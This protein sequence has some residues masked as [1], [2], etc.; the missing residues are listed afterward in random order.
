MADDHDKH[1]LKHRMEYGFFCF[2][3]WI[4]AK[5]PYRLALGV[6]WGIA[7]LGHYVMRYRVRLVYARIREVF[8]DLSPAR[9]RRVAWQSWRN[10]IFNIVDTFRLAQV[11]DAWLQ[12]HVLNYEESIQR[13]RECLGEHR[14]MVGVSLHMGCAEVIA[15]FLQ[16]MGLNV[17]IITGRQKNHLVDDRLNATRGKTGIACIPKDA[18]ISLFKQVFQRLRNGGSLVMLADLRLP[19]GGVNVDFLG[20]R[21][22]V[23]PGMGLFAKKSG[24]PVG[25]AIITRVGWTRHRLQVF[26]RMM[27]DETLSNENDVQRM[28]QTV[29]DIFDHAI[30]EQPEQWFWYNKNWIL[31]PVRQPHVAAPLTGE[32]A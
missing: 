13:V 2:W 19:T 20:G 14:G 31:A 6:G 18:G 9:V 5:A 29:F 21:A 32:S 11:D 23:V 30:R 27:A 15:V 16:R 24:V 12:K 1:S 25:T 8:P 22:S 28:T 4:F 10:F 7:W 3:G 17:F 26:P